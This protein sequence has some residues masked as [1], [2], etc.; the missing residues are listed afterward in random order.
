MHVITRTRLVEFWTKHP[1][2]KTSLQTWYRLTNQAKWQTLQDMQ[3]VFPSADLV[4]NLTVFNIGGNK[5]RLI[6]L[7][8]YSYQKV[9]IRHI[10]THAQYDKDDWKKDDW[11][12]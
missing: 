11:Y 6:A 4:S 8:D 12:T 2:A 7:V 3:A 1:D 9:F 5:Y 10:L